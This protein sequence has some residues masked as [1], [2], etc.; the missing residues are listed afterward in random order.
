[1]IRLPC[2]SEFIPFREEEEDEVWR[3]RE[4]RKHF[5]PIIRQPSITLSHMHSLLAFLYFFA[6]SLWHYFSMRKMAQK[7]S[8]YFFEERALTIDQLI[9]KIS[10]HHTFIREN[11]KYP[12]SNLIKI[13]YIFNMSS[14]EI[15]ASCPE[16]PGTK[17]QHLPL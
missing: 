14:P 17:L 15:P 7:M 10:I 16:V 6:G 11:D 9:L 2:H 1:M 8:I 13:K 3:R 4:I 12:K 5:W